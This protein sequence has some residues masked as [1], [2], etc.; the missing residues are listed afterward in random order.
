[1]QNSRSNFPFDMHSGAHFWWRKSGYSGCY[2]RFRSEDSIGT[3]ADDTNNQVV[4]GYV[5]EAFSK[6]DI[7]WVH[8]D[9]DSLGYYYAAEHSMYGGNEV[10]EIKKGD[11]IA[12]YYEETDEFISK[13]REV[14]CRKI[15]RIEKI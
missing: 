12:I 11:A 15:K 2:F 6:G 1:M 5:L 3:I 7:D 10:S 13:T 14:Y 4:V 9:D 8:F